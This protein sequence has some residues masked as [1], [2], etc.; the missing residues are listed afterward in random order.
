M[1]RLSKE[2]ETLLDARLPALEPLPGGEFVVY[3]AGNIGRAVARTL[4]ASGR[5]AIAFLDARV[6]GEVDGIPVHG[7]DSEAARSLAG[8]PVVIGVFNFAADPWPIRVLLEGLG[9]RRIVSFN[10]FHEHFALAPHFWLSTRD[11][12]QQNRQRVRAGWDL[13]CDEVSRRVFLDALKLRATHDLRLLRQP[14]W[15]SQ[16]LP[17]DLPQAAGAMRLVD[18]GAFTGDTVEYLLE[19]SVRFSALAAF[20]PDP[21]NFAKLQETARGKMELLGDAS[22]WP[23]GL[24]E[25]TEVVSFQAGQGSGSAVTR[26][27]DIHVQLVALDEVL[28]VFRPTHI[29]L[30]VEGSEMSALRGAAV[31][32]QSS[33]PRLAVCVYHRPDDLWEIPLYMRELLPEHQIALRYHTY[34]GFELVAYAFGKD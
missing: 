8:K 13:L 26:T 29:K 5:V 19:R 1:D 32:I 14:A 30:D 20:E 21:A 18:G 2:L 24:G 16:Y 3:G 34:Q 31:S 28:P 10:E 9:Y 11:H 23:C 25:K 7:P 12:A 17:D 6:R 4:L 15:G 27:G 22:L 33:Q